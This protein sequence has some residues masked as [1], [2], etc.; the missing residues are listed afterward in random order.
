MR[1]YSSG[2]NWKCKTA[3]GNHTCPWAYVYNQC[4][5]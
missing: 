5:E 4:P 2:S 3:T 1:C